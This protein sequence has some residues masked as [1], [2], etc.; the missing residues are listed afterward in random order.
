[1]YIRKSIEVFIIG[2]LLTTF[3]QWGFSHLPFD[4]VIKPNILLTFSPSVLCNLSI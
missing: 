3:C 4:H 2:Q 1:M